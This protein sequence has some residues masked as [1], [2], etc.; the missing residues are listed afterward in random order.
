MKAISAPE[1]YV[2]QTHDILFSKINMDNK[3]IKFRNIQRK[4]YN[5]QDLKATRHFL[6]LYFQLTTQFSMED[7]RF[8]VDIYFKKDSP[9]VISFNKA[10]EINDLF[11]DNAKVMS[12]IN[13]SAKEK[14]NQLPL[15]SEVK[16]LMTKNLFP[17]STDEI[18]SL[19]EKFGHYMTTGF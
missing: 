5:D 3:M 1:S 11:S 16:N 17:P 2:E 6:K 18:K 12:L 19:N 14:V 4:M 9:P 15:F 10:E 7:V 8:P 13:M